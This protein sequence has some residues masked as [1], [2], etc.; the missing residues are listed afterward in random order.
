MTRATGHE[1]FEEATVRHVVRGLERHRSRFALTEAR[2]A[3][4][5][6]P[7]GSGRALASEAPGQAG[8]VDARL[9]TRW[10]AGSIGSM[11]ATTMDL[12]GRT[13][14]DLTPVAPTGQRSPC[15][16]VIWAVRCKC[17]SEQLRSAI[18]LRRAIATHRHSAC[19]RCRRARRVDRYNTRA[20]DRV[21]HLLRAVERFDPDAMGSATHTQAWLRV[22]LDWYG[23]YGLGFD[24]R[25][26]AALRVEC[27]AALGEPVT[28][29]ERLDG[30]IEIA[31]GETES[32]DTHGQLWSNL[33]PMRAP[34]DHGYL[35][36]H[37]GATRERGWGCAECVVFVCY[38]C[39][40][41]E[42]HRCAEGRPG[43]GT[44]RDVADRLGV[45][46]QRVYQLEEKACCKVRKVWRHAEDEAAVK[47]RTAR[48]ATLARVPN[49]ALLERWEE[50]QREAA[51]E[52]R[53]R[54]AARASLPSAA[55][56]EPSRR[57]DTEA[58]LARLW[59]A[60]LRESERVMALLREELQRQVA[61][62]AAG[63]PAFL[64]WT[65]RYP[66]LPGI[67]FGNAAVVAETAFGVHSC[68]RCRLII[69]DDTVEARAH[70]RG[71]CA[72][73]FEPPFDVVENM[74]VQLGLAV[75]R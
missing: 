66:T 28:V 21:E 25:E 55:A 63:G 11:T 68:A 29:G 42:A 15:G 12:R 47:R 75:K 64:P 3:E 50:Q 43:F 56:P 16:S 45:S 61:V 53:K 52:Q 67:R 41:S 59:H 51:A 60:R 32:G 65:M 49:P 5:Q 69:V 57:R 30:P 74:R 14:G 26:T 31:A 7:P 36:A 17:G 10:G 33:Y 24:A 38:D 19:P 70:Q 8:A 20:E 37:C 73:V 9:T 34:V 27:G 18:D 44:L 13:I 58:G 62:H 6:A 72:L 22:A 39:G 2:M 48:A 46:A 23:L 40:K 71:D 54:A 35:C 1:S 4:T